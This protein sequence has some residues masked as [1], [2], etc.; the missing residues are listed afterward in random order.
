MPDVRDA[1][2]AVLVREVNAFCREV[3][4]PATTSYLPFVSSFGF[5]SAWNGA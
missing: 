4:D 1:V 3:E 2:R 5:S